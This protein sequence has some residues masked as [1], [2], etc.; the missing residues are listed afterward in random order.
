LNDQPQLHSTLIL[1]EQLLDEMPDGLHHEAADVRDNLVGMLWVPFH[2]PD[3]PYHTQVMQVGTAPIAAQTGSPAHRQVVGYGRFLAKDIRAEDRVQFSEVPDS[4]AMPTMSIHYDLTPR[5]R[6]NIDRALRLLTEEGR[7]LGTFL[8]GEEPRLL[9]AGS[10]MHYQGSVRMGAI[11]DGTCV[12][13][14]TSRVWATDNLYVAGNGVIPTATACNP[15]ATA[16]A[17]A[18]LAARSIVE[19]LNA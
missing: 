2:D 11:D 8:P 12:C 7:R 18:V 14:P 4:N 3:L 1:D 15:T 16:V 9:P 6:S 19:R 13:D 10:S 5:D 17:L